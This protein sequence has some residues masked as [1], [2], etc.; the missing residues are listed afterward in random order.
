MNSKNRVQLIALILLTSGILLLAMTTGIQ[1]VKAQTSN[2]IYVYTSCGGSVSANGANLN[3]GVTYNYTSGTAVTFTAT[4]ISGFSFLCWEYASQSA[5]G[6]STNNPFVYMP[7]ATQSAVQAMFVPAVNA[8]LTS[9]ST[10]TG[11][12][13]F[14]LLTSIGGTTSPTAGTYTNYSVGQMVNLAA[15]PGKGF[16]F[17]Y[18]LIPAATGGSSIITSS[19]FTF[20]VTANACAIQAYFVPTTSNITV[21]QTT[22]PTPTATP[23]INE[24]SPAII[25]VV[26]AVLAMTAFGTYTYKKRNRK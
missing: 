3:G 2:S 13:P 21:P 25:I 6:V 22:T 11:S 23:K 19:S 17:L 20:N 24:Y 12:S 26:L 9:S 4:P 10:Q 5:T 15:N 8:S 1:N 18:W 14:D 16:R 7:T